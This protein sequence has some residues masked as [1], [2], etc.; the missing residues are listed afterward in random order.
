MNAWQREEEFQITGPMYWKDF[1][2]RVLLS[3]L[4]TQNIGVSEAEWREQGEERCL[5][6]LVI[7]VRPSRHGRK[8]AIVVFL[9]TEV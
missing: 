8:F 6:D 5:R 7:S 9:E 2:P 3:I 1:P 4:G